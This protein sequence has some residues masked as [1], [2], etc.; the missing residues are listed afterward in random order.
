MKQL[1]VLLTML[2]FLSAN[3]QTDM[4][5][6]DWKAQ[7][8]PT[9]DDTLNNYNLKGTDWLVYLNNNKVLVKEK[10]KDN[11]IKLPFV[12]PPARFGTKK[13]PG[14]KVFI[15]VADGYLV[16]FSGGDYG[17]KLFWY[18][19][20]G[21]ENYVI[22]KKII[23]QFI[24]RGEQLFAIDDIEKPLIVE[25]KKQADKWTV[26]DHIKLEFSPEAIGLDA[27][28]NFVVA[29]VEDM[30]QITSEGKQ[31]VLIKEGFWSS[32]LYPNSLVVNGDEIYVGMRGG[33]FRYNTK[34]KKEEWLTK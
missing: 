23:R 1:T 27:K 18:S 34:T 33:V 6:A 2:C 4:P 26:Q 7:K 22:A 15:E 20:N 14:S 28:N 25:L 24:K 9:N 5:I 32:Q 16:A 21:Q 12:L 11:E 8:V 13:N 10:P 3:A 19:K 29:T 17:D 31:T 30:L